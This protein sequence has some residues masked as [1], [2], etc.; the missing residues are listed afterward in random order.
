M[1]HSSQLSPLRASKSSPLT[2]RIRVP[3]D[4]SISHRALILGALAV[5]ETRIQGLLE[6]EDVLNTAAG[7]DRGGRELRGSGERGRAHDDGGQRAHAD[8]RGGQHPERDAEQADRDGQWNGGDG[9]TAQLEPD[10]RREIHE[11]QMLGGR[12]R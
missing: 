12:R 1:T 4:K 7:K 3:G 2:G 10:G 9:A 5:G 11:P 8:A 6:S